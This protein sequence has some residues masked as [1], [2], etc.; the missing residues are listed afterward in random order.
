MS[1]PG[2]KD[3]PIPVV[4]NAVIWIAAVSAMVATLATFG[5][6]VAFV[7]SV[8][9]R[10]TGSPFD[11]TNIVSGLLVT[12][13]FA[14]MAWTTVRGEQVS[15]QVVTE[16]LSAKTNHILDLI[17]W[18]LGSAYVLW[19]MWASFERAI[20]R[21]WPIPETIIDGVGLAPLWPWRWVF[22]LSMI[23]FVM[24]VLLNLV[25]SIM[26]RKPYDDVMEVE[27]LVAAELGIDLDSIG[28]GLSFATT[29]EVGLPVPRDN[30]NEE[31]GGSQR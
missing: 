2:I 10:W 24:I 13:T 30:A 18:T 21:T 6:V 8:V 29:P 11:V 22:A 27:E 23:P 3:D 4:E 20:S 9:G 1:A 15:V 5:I 16:R 26:G 7:G 28:E 19:L 12:A 31:N 14:G 17:I 25:R